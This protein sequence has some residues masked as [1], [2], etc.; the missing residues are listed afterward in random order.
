[1]VKRHC[2]AR[3]RWT[4]KVKRA[5]SVSRETREGLA[6]RKMTDSRTKPQP[7]DVPT[8]TQKNVTGKHH[9]HFLSMFFL[10]LS[11][12]LLVSMSSP[13]RSP[14]EFASLLHSVL[15]FFQGSIQTTISSGAVF[16]SFQ[17]DFHVS[18]VRR[19]LRRFLLSFSQ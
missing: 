15:L 13:K 4:K 3:G 16:L 11:N 19:K 1:M 9:C 18:G 6:H 17:L 5:Q 10:K 2:A 12:L 7:S 8:L 14:V